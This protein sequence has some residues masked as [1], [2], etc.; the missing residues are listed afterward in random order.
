MNIHEELA[1]W[2][3][4]RER[5]QALI[6]DIDETICTH[7]DQ[8]ISL[9]CKILKALTHTVKIYYVTARPETCKKATEHFLALHQLPGQGKVYYCPKWKSSTQHK[10]EVIGKLAKEYDVLLSIGDHEEEQKASIA[11][12]IPFAKIDL[13]HP[14]RS[15]QDI[16]KRLL[17]LDL[18][19]LHP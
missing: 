14:E 16:Q 19:E 11:A 9:A 12:D 7:F 5:P 3:A 18:L 4:Q 6:L 1:K 13:L 15:W 10:L 8:P 17:A 2:L